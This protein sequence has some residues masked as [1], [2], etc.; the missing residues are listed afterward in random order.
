MKL[1]LRKPD[2]KSNQCGRNQFVAGYLDWPKIAANP[3]A[4]EPVLQQIVTVQ[5]DSGKAVVFALDRSGLTPIDRV[6]VRF[7]IGIL[8]SC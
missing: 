6:T 1:S 3:V 2:P 7:R 4:F 5:L 8:Q